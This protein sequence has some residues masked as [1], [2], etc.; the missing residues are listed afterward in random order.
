MVTIEF[1]DLT[2]AFDDLCHKMWDMGIT[3]VEAYQTSITHW[4]KNCFPGNDVQVR[5]A[6]NGIKIIT[7]KPL[8]AQEVRHFMSMFDYGHLRVRRYMTCMVYTLVF[9]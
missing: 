9:E 5:F 1:P 2:P 6:G 7:N 3:I 4:I 8:P